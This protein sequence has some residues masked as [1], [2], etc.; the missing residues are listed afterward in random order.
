MAGQYYERA[1]PQLLN[2]LAISLSAS[3]KFTLAAVDG[4][5][6]PSASAVPAPLAAK[7]D[8]AT[9]FYILYGL[10][11]ETLVK[12]LGDSSTNAMAQTA[13]RAMTYL[14]RPEISG[15]T[16]FQGAFFDELCTVAYRIAMSEPA[17]VKREMVELMS[18]FAT[19]RVGSN[20]FDHG[21]TRRI[22]A[23]ITFV[24]RG[25]IP[26]AD[27]Q[28]SFTYADTAGE[29]VA[30]LRSAFSAFARVVDT[31]D[32]A[33]R[34][35]L[36][37]VGLHLFTDVLRE[38]ST[39]DLAGSLLGNLKNL[40]EGLVKGQVPGVASDQGEKVVAGLLGA[41]VTNIDDMR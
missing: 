10:S 20:A 41:C 9:N 33:Q 23:V 14:V 35:D 3:E 26:S 21:Q 7:A 29:R 15:T 40:L 1:V 36:F 6:V 24:L 2:A 28:S 11:F 30:F 16:V 34:A 22:L 38:E 37:A 25:T 8:P 31:I 5:S 17:I 19:S 27:V 18:A 12:S 4:Q 32:A 13:L 39:M